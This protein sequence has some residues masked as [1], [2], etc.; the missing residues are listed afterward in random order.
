MQKKHSAVFTDPVKRKIAA[1][2]LQ[3]GTSALFGHISTRCAYFS[4]PR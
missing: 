3:N 2:R 1:S 4:K